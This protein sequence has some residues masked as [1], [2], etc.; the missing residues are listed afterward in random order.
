MDRLRRVLRPPAHRG[1]GPSLG[2]V[3]T[4][5]YCANGRPR[6]RCAIASSP[7]RQRYRAYFTT[8]KADEFN[9]NMERA[10]SSSN[11]GTKLSSSRWRC[12]IRTFSRHRPTST[13]TAWRSGTTS[14]NTSK[15]SPADAV[16]AGGEEGTSPDPPTRYR[17][18]ATQRTSVGQRRGAIK[19]ALRPD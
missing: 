14:S 12:P 18:G 9:A 11:R 16:D 8:P 6:V 7:P 1:L 19:P 2:A 3:K 5:H 10:K 17:C 13:S 15:R 4:I